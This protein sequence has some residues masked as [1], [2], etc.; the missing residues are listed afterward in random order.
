MNNSD[1]IKLQ[2]M[3]DAARYAKL[4]VKGS[5]RANLNDDVMLRFALTKAI[6]IIGEAAANISKDTRDQL[7][8]F[9]WGKIVGMRNRLVHVYFDIDLDILWD[10]VENYIP[11]LINDLEKLKELK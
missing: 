9:E 4:F 11:N 2:H 1:I 6:E 8:H 7:P 3:L 10:T 5:T